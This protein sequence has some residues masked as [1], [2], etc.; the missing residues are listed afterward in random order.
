[1]PL[2]FLVMS[3][4]WQLSLAAPDYK[5]WMASGKCFGFRGEVLLSWL[6][7]QYCAT[8]CNAWFFQTAQHIRMEMHWICLVIVPVE[9]EIERQII[10][11]AYIRIIDIYNTVYIYHYLIHGMPTVRKITAGI[12]ASPSIGSDRHGLTVAM[13][14][15]T[16]LV[17][18]VATF[19]LGQCDGFVSDTCNPYRGVKKIKSLGWLTSCGK[20]CI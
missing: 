13:F 1:M 6:R 5:S 18:F 17:T 7:I 2:F 15:P 12:K 19:T 4:T 14:G 9:T 20:C 8:Q 11:T 16:R 10:Y 3:L